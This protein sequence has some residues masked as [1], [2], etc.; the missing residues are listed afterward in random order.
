M[1]TQGV[2]KSALVAQIKRD[3]SY[4][5]LASSPDYKAWLAERP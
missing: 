4:R 2:T 3:K 5:G 1:T